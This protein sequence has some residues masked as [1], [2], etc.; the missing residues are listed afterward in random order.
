MAWQLLVYR[1][2]PE[3][4]RARVA[5]WRQLRRLGALPLQ[6]SVA[7]VPERDELP[8]R[9]DA[10]QRR[11][12]EEGGR[13]WRFGLGDLSTEQELAL[14]GEWSALRS[15]EY[16]EIV[17]ECDTKFAREVEFELFRGNVT[18]AEAEE[19]EADLEKIRTWFARV[20]ARDL[21]EAPGRSEVQAA[22]AR[23]EALLEDFVERAY[24]LETEHGP[25][26]EP[27]ADLPWGEGPSGARNPR[28]EDA[29]GD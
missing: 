6:Q 13:V 18:G 15:Q 24:R 25:S 1:L 12:E 5:V 4:S 11:I 20:E 22:I 23:C 7:A 21:F 29:R 9:L 14:Q 27:P 17:E 8:T 10:I 19:I 2:P 3:S 28:R 26:L 16:A